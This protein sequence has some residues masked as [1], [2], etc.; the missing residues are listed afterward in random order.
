MAAE[1]ELARL[2]AEANRRVPDPPGLGEVIDVIEDIGRRRLAAYDLYAALLAG[3]IG[4]DSLPPEHWP[5]ELAEPMARLGLTQFAP[6]TGR[7]L[8]AQLTPAEQATRRSRGRQLEFAH[9]LVDLINDGAFG[10]LCGG[11][12]RVRLVGSGERRGL[13]LELIKGWRIV[14][15]CPV[16]DHWELVAEHL[17][18][19]PL[20][21]ALAEAEN[22]AGSRRT[23]SGRLKHGGIPQ[24]VSLGVTLA[25]GLH[26]VGTV[27]GLGARLIQ[28]RIQAGQDHAD[29]LR[30]LGRD[31]RA[32]H[33]Q[34][35]GELTR[36]QAGEST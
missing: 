21:S 27:A 1:G 22:P 11:A 4:D 5:P 3:V 7:G 10:P 26:P 2:R 23:V 19:V 34:A 18:G 17:A 32:L 13:D 9:L 24:A 35:D 16:K 15:A 6:R 28:V 31:L 36:V 14:G 20:S 30:R 33:A 29:A 25:V 12:D 8:D